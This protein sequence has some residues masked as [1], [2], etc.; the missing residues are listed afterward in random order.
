MEI[1]SSM[2]GELTELCLEG[3]LTIM[4]AAEVRDQLAL[5]L[6]TAPGRVRVNLSKI[7]ELD[8]AG[9]QLLLALMGER[10]RVVLHQPNTLVRL[11]VGQAGLAVV[12]GLEESGDGA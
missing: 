11:R 10:E 1:N 7:T 8:T 2:N 3:A 4:E 9:L 6:V 5:C 12:L